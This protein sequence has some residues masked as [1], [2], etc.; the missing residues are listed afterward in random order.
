MNNKQYPESQA[1]SESCW[2]PALLTWRCRT[3]CG[4]I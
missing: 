3:D 1:C 2:S 4:K